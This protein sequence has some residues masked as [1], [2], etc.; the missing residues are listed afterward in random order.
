MERLSG[1]LEQKRQSGPR[2]VIVDGPSDG[3]NDLD[4]MRFKNIIF[5]NT[6]IS[7]KGGPLVLDNVYFVNC[8]FT[9]ARDSGGQ[10]FAKSIL[11]TA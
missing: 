5:T 9:I 10:R 8:T 6:A 2:Y 1:G 11:Q 4:E 3:F 7:Y